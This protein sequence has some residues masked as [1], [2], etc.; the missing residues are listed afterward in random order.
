MVLEHSSTAV[1]TL[2]MRVACLG[3]ALLHKIPGRTIMSLL[4][5]G[6]LRFRWD[7]GYT[8]MQRG[9]ITLRITAGIAWV[10]LPLPPIPLL[11][12]SNQCNATITLQSF[13]SPYRV[14]CCPPPP[15]HHHLRVPCTQCLQRIDPVHMQR[16]SASRPARPPPRAVPGTAVH[17]GPV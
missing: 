13:F 17:K 1:L 15:P 6:L 7:H 2:N 9:S 16:D 12:T 8:I 4:A 3:V 10:C 5:L 14:R 11:P